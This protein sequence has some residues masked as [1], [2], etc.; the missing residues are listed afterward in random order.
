MGENIYPAEVERVLAQH[1]AIADC[2]V[3]GVPDPRWG[4]AVKAIVVLRAG[5]TIQEADLPTFARSRIAA[6]K[7]P[8][9]VDL[10]VAPV[11]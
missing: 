8:K 11:V 5:H 4:E 10:E 2:A 7:C 3:I 9:S 1:P 6:F